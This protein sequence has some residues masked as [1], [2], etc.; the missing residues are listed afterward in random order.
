MCKIVLAHQ[1]VLAKALRDRRIVGVDFPQR[2]ATLE[3]GFEEFGRPPLQLAPTRVLSLVG[4]L[5]EIAFGLGT[6]VTA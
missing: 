4:N 5:L 6:G 3:P 1:R 2:V